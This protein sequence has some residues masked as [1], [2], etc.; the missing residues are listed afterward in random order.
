MYVSSMYNE[1][2]C[3]FLQKPHLIVCTLQ[4]ST[5]RPQPH[6]HQDPSHN[7]INIKT[8]PTTT[9]R[10]SPQ[11]H[12]HQDPAHMHIKTQPT[13]TSTSRPSQQPHQHQEET[14]CWCSYGG[15]EA[16]AC[17]GSSTV[18]LEFP[19]EHKEKMPEEGFVVWAFQI[20]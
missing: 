12:Q 1:N 17:N 5:P 14:F 20:Y 8:P 6:Q 19:P 9:S 15:K 10:P 4:L 11:P 2:A 13:T 7:H 18:M 16:D 3:M